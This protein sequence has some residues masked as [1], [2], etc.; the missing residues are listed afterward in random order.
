MAG[1]DDLQ[2]ANVNQ[3]S[4]EQDSPICRTCWM[5]G[6]TINA[7][8]DVYGDNHVFEYIQGKIDFEYTCEEN[9]SSDRVNVTGD[10][11]HRFALQ[12]QVASLPPTA[13]IHF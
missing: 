11:G 8:G 3:E 9:L 7:L 2:T 5:P 12:K 13:L 4:K 6:S 1:D 10:L